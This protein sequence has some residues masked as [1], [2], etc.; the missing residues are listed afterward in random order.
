MEL[1]SIRGCEAQGD[2]LQLDL[3]VFVCGGVG[4]G[5]RGG[6]QQGAALVSSKYWGSVRSA[7][8]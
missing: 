1:D 6:A 2:R 3:W 5:G 7:W 8:N 4:G